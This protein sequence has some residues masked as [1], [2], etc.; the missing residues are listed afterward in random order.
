MSLEI[1]LIS[2]AA[3]TPVLTIF[4]RCN[5]VDSIELP[6]FLDA[7]PPP[8][9]VAARLGDIVVGGAIIYGYFEI[10]AVIAVEP[11][12]RRQG[13]GR[14]LIEQIGQWAAFRGGSWVAVADE[15]G[16]AVHPFAVALGLSRLK[17]EVL[18]ELDP[19][20][21]PPLPSLPPTWQTRLADTN[22]TDAITAIVA[23]AFNDPHE[24][25]AA[26]V[27]DRITHPV[28]RFVIGEI[29]GLP[30]A[31]M[32]L[33]RTEQGIMITTFGV[34][35]NQQGHGYGRLLLLTTV[36]RLLAAGYERIR[37]EVEETNIPAY[38]LYRSCGFVPRR[39]YGQYGRRV[40]TDT[41]AE[42]P[43]SAQPC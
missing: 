22:D 8:S 10:E 42:S 31:V 9:L 32:R 5:R 15:A 28:H 26:F 17:V 18:L 41:A 19:T 14:R 35:R 27:A 1:S 39:R 16:P 13:I 40:Q 12:W 4:D 34:R 29:D 38:Q 6:V 23:D 2:S 7:E 20:W 21:L 3:W 30:V 43:T 25:V 11:A 37:I 24:Q 33:L 36:H